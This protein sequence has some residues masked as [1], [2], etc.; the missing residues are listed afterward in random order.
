M[1]NN[2]FYLCMIQL[3]YVFNMSIN[4]NYTKNV[5]LKQE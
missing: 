3:S 4:H 5:L 1:Y 2:D